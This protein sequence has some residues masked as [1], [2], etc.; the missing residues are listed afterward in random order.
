[1]GT[2]RVQPLLR[3]GSSTLAAF[4]AILV[5]ST[6]RGDGVGVITVAKTL[7]PAT[8]AVIDPESGTSS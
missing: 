8:V 4:L 7:P 1:M 5:A 3:V 2:R 6:A